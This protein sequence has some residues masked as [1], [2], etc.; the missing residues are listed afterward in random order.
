MTGSTGDG[1]A[2]ETISGELGGGVSGFGGFGDDENFKDLEGSGMLEVLEMKRECFEEDM[3][4]LREERHE[5]ETEA[6]ALKLNQFGASGF[7]V[8][9]RLR[10]ENCPKIKILN[11]IS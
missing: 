10:E 6:I 7:D 9:E 2:S 3:M 5:E 1:A 4:G 11:I 8:V